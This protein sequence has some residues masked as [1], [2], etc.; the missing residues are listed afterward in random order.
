MH[1]MEHNA[2]KQE[3]TSECVP[4]LQ[5]SKIVF[6]ILSSQMSC[7]VQTDSENQ[8]TILA[9]DIAGISS[10]KPINPI[11]ITYFNAEGITQTTSSPFSAVISA[12]LSANLWAG[13]DEE[14]AVTDDNVDQEAVNPFKKLVVL[15]YVRFDR[16]SDNLP[17]AA[18][19]EFVKEIT[20]T[21]KSPKNKTRFLIIGG[22]PW[23]IRLPS[24][25]V[26]AAEGISLQDLSEERLDERA[27]ALIDANP[28]LS[29]K[30]LTRKYIEHLTKPYEGSRD[31]LFLAIREYIKINR[32]GLVVAQETQP[33]FEAAR[34]KK[35]R[36]IFKDKSR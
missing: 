8:A 20:Q 9:E 17:F 35:I 4:R 10:L 31:G 12:R 16:L 21:I 29:K 33:G 36:K 13:L 6:D 3:I 28:G 7:Y 26:L 14:N 2:P 24:A 23:R 25:E 27:E 5:A 22:V 11:G 34:I 19:P 15:K 30:G 18:L 1:R 32:L